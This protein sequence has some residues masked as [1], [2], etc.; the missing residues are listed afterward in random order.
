MKCKMVWVT[1]TGQTLDKAPMC[2]DACMSGI[3]VPACQM[4][5]A[6]SVLYGGPI[7]VVSL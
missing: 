4:V 6:V 2:A 5:S 1:G 7:F 3:R